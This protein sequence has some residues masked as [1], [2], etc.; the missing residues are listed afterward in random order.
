MPPATPYVVKDQS[1]NYFKELRLL[2]IIGGQAAVKA[3]SAGILKRDT[4]TVRLTPDDPDIGGQVFSAIRY[5]NGVNWR[6]R[7]MRLPQTKAWHTLIY[8]TMLEFNREGPGFVLL[9]EWGVESAADRHLLFL[10]RRID[11]PVHPDW[12]DWLWKRGLQTGEIKPL[13]G[14][15]LSAW[16]CAP[17]QE[18]LKEQISKAIRGGIL[19][20]PVGEAA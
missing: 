8:S 3:I 12:K 1:E 5:M 15:G 11:L 2:S 4:E 20:A 18:A 13:L 14:L 9:G 19:T 7:T 10:N 17:D 16:E 6:S